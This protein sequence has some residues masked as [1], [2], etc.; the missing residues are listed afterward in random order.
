MQGRFADA[1]LLALRLEEGGH[2][3]RKPL[4]NGK[5]KEMHSLLEP[6]EGSLL[7][8]YLDFS[9]VKLISDF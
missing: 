8:G 6:P 2:E 5:G 7:G 9:L 4:E 1:R 3:P